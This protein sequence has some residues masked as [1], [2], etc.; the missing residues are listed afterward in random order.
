MDFQ[1]YLNRNNGHIYQ[2][3]IVTFENVRLFS[4]FKMSKNDFL[5]VK[6]PLLVQFI[7]VISREESHH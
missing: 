4:I 5:I 3:V 2:I 1:Y 6:L 7:E